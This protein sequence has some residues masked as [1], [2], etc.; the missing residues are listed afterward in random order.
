MEVKKNVNPTIDEINE[1]HSQ[2]CT[3]LE[4]LFEKNKAKYI[5]DYKNVKLE[6]E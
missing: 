5:A 3:V 1:V 6:I 2:F 4:E